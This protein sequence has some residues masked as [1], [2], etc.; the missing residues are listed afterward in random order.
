MMKPPGNLP[1]TH[2][3]AMSPP[4][5]SVIVHREHPSLRS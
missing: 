1:N 4:N 5:P 3:I 2:P